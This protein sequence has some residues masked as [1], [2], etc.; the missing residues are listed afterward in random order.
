MASLQEDSN[1]AEGSGQEMDS[2]AIHREQAVVVIMIAV[3]QMTAT[4]VDVLIASV[5]Q[6]I[7]RILVIR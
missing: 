6:P 1:V 3:Q 2:A 7:L 4:V 5:V